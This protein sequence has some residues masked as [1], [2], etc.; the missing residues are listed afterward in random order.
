MLHLIV[1]GVAQ[2]KGSTRA[3]I[4]KGW[5]RPII[6]NDNPKNKSWQQLIA[7]GASRAIQALPAAERG[8]LLAGVRLTIAFYLPTPKKY[9]TAKYQRPGAVL[10]PHTTKPDASKLLR[11]VEDALTKVAFHDDAQVV[12]LVVMKRYTPWNQT[13]R[14]EVWVEA[15]AGVVALPRAQPL[16]EAVR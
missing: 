1:L 2:T 12:E 10:P 3:F 11:S 16:F 15:T 4:P 8:P 14:A 5:K 9:Q 13:P 6:T 7:E